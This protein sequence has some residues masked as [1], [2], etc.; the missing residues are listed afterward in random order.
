MAKIDTVLKYREAYLAGKSPEK[1]ERFLA[2]DVDKQYNSIMT[3]RY[4]E[5]QRQR[6]NEMEKDPVNVLNRL[7]DSIAEMPLDV[8][9][10]ENLMLAMRNF[11]ADLEARLKSVR[12][13]ELA[14]L[15]QERADLAERIDNL[16][17]QC[18]SGETPS[19]FTEI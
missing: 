16:R 13:N 4:H 6:R 10:I 17:R 5:R 11:Y 12:E 3:W 19:L 9:N 8:D 1:R 14:N 2:R 15:E 7:R 18:E